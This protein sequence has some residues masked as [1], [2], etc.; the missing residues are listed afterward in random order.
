MGTPSSITT[1]AIDI[2]LLYLTDKSPSYNGPDQ[3]LFKT[4]ARDLDLRHICEL[5]MLCFMP[6]VTWVHLFWLACPLTIPA[7]TS[8]IGLFKSRG[9]VSSLHPSLS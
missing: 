8:G 3:S 1:F 6:Y 9:M 7:H 5:H 4:G 2:A